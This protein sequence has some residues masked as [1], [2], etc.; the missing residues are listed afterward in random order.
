MG[1]DPSELRQCFVSCWAWEKD[2][3]PFHSC[4]GWSLDCWGALY[5]H[6]THTRPLSTNPPSS[7]YPIQA[8]AYWLSKAGPPS[9][10]FINTSHYSG[11]GLHKD[12]KEISTLFVRPEASQPFGP[13]K[14]KFR[15]SNLPVLIFVLKRCVHACK[16]IS[17]IFQLSPKCLFWCVSFLN[18][19]I[20]FSGNVSEYLEKLN[21]W[22]ESL[23]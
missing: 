9:Q 14:C 21:R 11:T 7:F 6:H 4:L 22:K 19:Q 12:S 16:S 5:P 17:P 18:F 1:L 3:T 15:L 10:P 2:G 23:A 13:H 20:C 8:P